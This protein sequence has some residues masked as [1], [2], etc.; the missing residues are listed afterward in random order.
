MDAR[1][2]QLFKYVTP[3]ASR[4]NLGVGVTLPSWLRPQFTMYLN[5]LRPAGNLD[6]LPGAKSRNPWNLVAVLH[7][8]RSVLIFLVVVHLMKTR[9]L[10]IPQRTNRSSRPGWET[11]HSVIWKKGPFQLWNRSIL[12]HY[13]TWTGFS[14]PSHRW[15]SY[16][17]G[18]HVNRMQQIRAER[19]MNF[20]NELTR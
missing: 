19:R 4:R 15:I 2:T 8:E 12:K 14:S 11:P 17:L 10:E 13:L 9:D 16:L 6:P 18:A 7:S 1:N 3:A 5:S 20:P